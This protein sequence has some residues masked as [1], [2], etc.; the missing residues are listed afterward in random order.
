M[1]SIEIIRNTKKSICV[2]I[3]NVTM[4][5]II[6]Y[7]ILKLIEFISNNLKSFS[8]QINL[9]IYKQSI[10]VITPILNSCFG[11]TFE[12]TQTESRYVCIYWFQSFSNA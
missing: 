2:W 12:N 6:D 11:I 1:K 5:Q 3:N 9:F 7:I 10:Q 8:N 4:F